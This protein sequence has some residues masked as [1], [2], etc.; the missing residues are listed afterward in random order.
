MI[1][2]LIASGAVV[3]KNVTEQWFIT[4][5]SCEYYQSMLSDELI[6]KWIFSFLSQ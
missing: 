1:A 6:K 3:T 4:V 5:K 2:K